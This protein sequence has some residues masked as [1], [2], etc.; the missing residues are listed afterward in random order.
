MSSDDSAPTS[1]VRRFDA[2]DA[3]AVANI[4]KDSPDAA[5]WS[6]ESYAK[7]CKQDG[8]VWVAEA[9]GTVAGFLAARIASTEAEILNLAVAPA[10]RRARIA[11]I[12]L[13]KAFGEFRR[14]HAT[15]VFVEVRESN[16]GA[17]RF[18]ENHGFVRTGRRP[19]YYQNPV[20]AAVLLTRKLTA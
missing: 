7:L 13:H 17:L 20:E 5:Q 3:T 19:S 4:T 14:L 9:A 10:H 8:L 15:Q 1:L 2:R 18:Y 11:T 6:Q 12:L 16:A